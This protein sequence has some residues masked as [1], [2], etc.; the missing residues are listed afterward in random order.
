[1][2][3]TG[4]LLGAGAS[5]EFGMPLA[6]ELTRELKKWL[7]PAK[8]RELN[9]E[10]QGQGAGYSR[11]TI[12]DLAGVLA[13]DRMNYEDIVGYLE[14]QRKR[15]RERTDEYHGL[16]AFLSEIIYFLLKERHVL[17]G[18]L[19]VRNIKYLDGIKTFV[20]TNRPL[21]VFSL[22]HDLIVECFAAHTGTS[23][24][25]GFSEEVVRLPRR[26]MEGTEIGEVE[27][28]VTRRHQLDRHALN[29]FQPDE[30]GINLLKIHG[31][32][33]E[34]A[35][36]DG[37]D[38]LKV[39]PDDSSTLGAI[40]ALRNANAEVRYIDPR[41]PGG[42]VKAHNQIPYADAEGEMQFLRRTP[43]AGAFK[44]QG[45][46][47]QTVP[48]ELLSYFTLSLSY[49]AKLI[50][51]GYGFGDLHVNQAIRDWLEGSAE[52]RLTIVDP[53]IEGVPMA[54]HHLSPQVELVKLD[55]TAY[56]DRIANISRTRSE[57]IERQFGTVLRGKDQQETGL[58]IKQY[59]DQLTEDVVTRMV[60][61]VKT[62]PWRDGSIDLKE[63]GLTMDDFLR[64]ARE[65]VPMPS[66]ED[67]LEEFLKQATESE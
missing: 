53:S 41:W 22:N 51:I 24:K 16:L 3:L 43:L 55:T 65:K 38:L 29:F 45:R 33:D 20:D 67:A 23:I 57:Q 40:S 15:I 18:D 49:L 48:N 32:L 13:M 61:W 34:F 10:W 27:A 12:D 54:L 6:L 63:L 50:C 26:D 2:G 19:I 59:M 1:M 28:R 46:F 39:M 5:F 9:D 56:L 17:N 62:L 30:K 64:I 37:K 11:A 14:V 52:R 44:F 7:T 58:M 66:R 21:W 47:S 36:N 25:C 35:F 8:L 4:L 31:S 42:V 60:E